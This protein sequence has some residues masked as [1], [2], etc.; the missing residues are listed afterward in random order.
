MKEPQHPLK[1]WL[2]DNNETYAGF[3]GRIGCTQAMVSFWI[4]RQSNPT[5]ERMV[6]IARAT[7]GEIM[8][9]DFLPP[10]WNAKRGRPKKKA[11]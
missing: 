11:A 6:A 4:N 5:M 3:A 7:D 10:N 9:N 2:F 8:P 1:R